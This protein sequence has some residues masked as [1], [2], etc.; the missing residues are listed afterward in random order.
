VFALL[1]VVRQRDHITLI[2]LEPAAAVRNAMLPVIILYTVSS[3]VH[4]MRSPVFAEVS[5]TT[6]TL[7][8]SPVNEQ[9]SQVD[10]RM[11]NI[12]IIQTVSMTVNN[13][14][15]KRIALLPSTI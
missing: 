12:L 7:A 14:T 4:L 15:V 9:M 3:L 2:V 13:Q 11:R 10:A 1:P 5:C 8:S 6:M